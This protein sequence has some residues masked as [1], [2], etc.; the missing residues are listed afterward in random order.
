MDINEYLDCIEI[1]SN[2]LIDD[3]SVGTFIGI[4]D[5]A[6]K[7]WKLA[8]YLGEYNIIISRNYK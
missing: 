6:K 2:L 3:Q 5:Q 8:I 7:C 1:Q 4:S